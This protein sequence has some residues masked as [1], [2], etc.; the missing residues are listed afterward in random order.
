MLAVYEKLSS[1]IDIEWTIVGGGPDEI[2]FKNEIAKRVNCKIT[3]LGILHPLRLSNLYK[4]ADI[5]WLCSLY[6]EGLG[7]VYLEAAAYCLPSIGLNRGGVVESIW[8]DK[9]GLIIDNV[10]ESYDAI[11]KLN[12]IVFLPENFK[13][14]LS[15]RR[16]FSDFL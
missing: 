4:D 9:T 15:N 16:N 14:L 10:E 13:S 8:H 3:Y 7:L 2:L 6:E 12:E 5:F 1:C 11:I